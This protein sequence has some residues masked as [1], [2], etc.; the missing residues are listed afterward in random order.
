MSKEKT[1]RVI[2][3]KDRSYNG[4]GKD[5]IVETKE[6]E[7]SEYLSVGFEVIREK[8]EEVKE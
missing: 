7:L 1:I 3:P 4:I 8:T 5:T 2:N 6:S